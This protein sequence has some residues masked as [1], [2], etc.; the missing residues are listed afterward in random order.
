MRTHG[1]TRGTATK[2]AGGYWLMR[3]LKPIRVHH[4]RCFR[5]NDWHTYLLLAAL[6][7]CAQPFPVA[8]QPLKVWEVSP[9]PIRKHCETSINRRLKQIEFLV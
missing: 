5:N 6:R 1:D 2:C 9:L 4:V 8:P 3:R 7:L